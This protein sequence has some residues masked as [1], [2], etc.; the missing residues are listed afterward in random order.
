MAGGSRCACLCSAVEALAIVLLEEDLANGVVA[1]L[2]RLEGADD[3]DRLQLLALATQPVDDLLCLCLGQGGCGRAGCTV[4][5]RS[6][7]PKH[8]SIKQLSSFVWTPLQC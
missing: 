4:R 5:R 6:R 7:G 3:L 2:G 1:Q 8:F